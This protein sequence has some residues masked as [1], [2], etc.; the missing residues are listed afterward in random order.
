[1]NLP[2]HHSQL[3]P[4][5]LGELVRIPLNRPGDTRHWV[6]GNGCKHQ[7][8]SD[9]KVPA[10]PLMVHK[11]RSANF[12]FARIVF[13]Y[14]LDGGR[15]AKFTRKRDGGLQP[16]GG[17]P[18]KAAAKRPVYVQRTPKQQTAPQGTRTYSNSGKPM[19]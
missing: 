19:G 10:Q 5:C 11:D 15:P 18:R 3:C 8:C 16:D 14:M 1:M 7:A 6:C 4:R 17:G 9:G 12:H 13:G 2:K